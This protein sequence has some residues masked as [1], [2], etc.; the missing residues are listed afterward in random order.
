[1]SEEK[2]MPEISGPFGK[3]PWGSLGGLLN[4]AH[5]VGVPITIAED[6]R[7]QNEGEL[8]YREECCG[9][10]KWYVGIDYPL[11]LWVGEKFQSYN[12][13]IVVVYPE[14]K[15][16]KPKFRL[17]LC[18]HRTPAFEISGDLATPELHEFLKAMLTNWMDDPRYK[19][20]QNAGAFFQGGSHDPNGKWFLIEFWKPEGAQA[21]VDYINEHFE[22]PIKETEDEQV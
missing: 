20:N 11:Y 7:L 14:K 13:Q 6:L 19:L 2:T 8:H 22:Y 21:F 9:Y 15:V 12:Q 4:E 5:A 17:T 1:M 10:Y 18:T 16:M 3:Y